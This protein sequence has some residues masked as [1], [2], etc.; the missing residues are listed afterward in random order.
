M[1][2]RTLTRATAAALVLLAVPAVSASPA[3]AGAFDYVRAPNVKTGFDSVVQNIANRPAMQIETDYYVYGSGTG[4]NDPQVWLTV[5]ANKNPG[6]VTLFIYWHDRVSG[7]QLFY[8]GALGFTAVES[9]L[10]GSPGA[11]LQITLGDLDNFRLFGDDSAFGPLPSEIPV[12]TGRYQ[13]VAEV[14]NAKGTTVLART[15]TLYNWVDGVE[16]HGGELTSS[17]RWKSSDLHY[18][19]TPLYVAEGAVLTIDPGTVILGSKGGQGTLIIRQGAKI[20]AAGKPLDPIIFSSELPVGDRGPGDWGGL[21]VNG[22]APTNRG[23]SPLP[24]GEGDSGPF[25][26]TDANDSS[27]VLSYMRLEF[28]GIRFSEQNELNGIAFQGVGRGTQV[29]HIQVH[30]NQD[31]GIEMFGGT[32]EAKYL[33]LTADQDDS[34]DWTDGWTG[35]VQYVAAVQSGKDEQDQG[36][37]ADNLEDDEDALPRSSPEIRN[38]TFIGDLLTSAPLADDDGNLIRRGTRLD[39][40]NALIAYFPS[41]GVNIDGSISQG[42]LGGNGISYDNV[43]LFGNGTANTKQPIGQLGSNISTADPG[44]FNSP[45]GRDG[46]GVVP[47]LCFAN[48]QAAGGAGSGTFFD[49]A[50]Y[51][52]AIDCGN[53]DWTQTGWAT[54]A[55]N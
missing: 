30:R 43:I 47:D 49:R 23:L 35:R 6:P 5:Q 2:L 44:F 3:A 20:M 37:E 21:V 1:S 51:I 53:S 13:F 52:G 15:N 28:A 22:F 16:T 8:N 25:G 36:I 32:T 11:P 41:Y 19:E 55:D 27:G 10:F 40:D 12:T 48:G 38:A 42:F 24:E 33:L 29:D 46:G 50:A 18:L 7:A 34:L 4:F 39:M 31:D 26:G 14:R 54:W 9:D 17:E 45:I